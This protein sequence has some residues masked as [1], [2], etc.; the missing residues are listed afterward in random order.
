[1]APLADSADVLSPEAG[2]SL[3][4]C[5]A[6]A[7]CFSRAVVSCREPVVGSGYRLSA[8]TCCWPALQVQI[9]VVTDGGRILGLGDLGTNGMG[10]SGARL[11]HSV[12]VCAAPLGSCST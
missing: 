2:P 9:I 11:L 5:A 4:S 10:I 8:G 6:P 1:M 7:S 3:W 12:A